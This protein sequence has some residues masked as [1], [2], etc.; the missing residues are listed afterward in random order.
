MLS[1]HDNVYLDCGFGSWI[2]SGSNW[3]APY[4]EWQKFYDNDPKKILEK[5]GITDSKKQQLVIGGE[6]AMWSEQ[7]SKHHSN[8]P[9]INV[10]DFCSL[11][12]ILSISTQ[13]FIFL[14][15]SFQQ[16]LLPSPFLFFS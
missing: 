14:S 6:A 16:L 9:H 5:F 2:S 1:N 4:K 15:S 8:C 10:G 3:C 7:V 11:L 12:F 13:L